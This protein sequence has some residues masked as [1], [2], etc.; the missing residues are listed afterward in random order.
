MNKLYLIDGNALAY[1]AFYAIP[2]LATSKGQPTN[3]IY[4]FI[5]ILRKILKEERVEYLAVFFDS[6]APTFRHSLFPEY[7]AQRKKMPDEL[8]G[9]I[10]IICKAIESLGCFY[11]SLNGYE[12]DDLIASSVKTFR[13][14][15]DEIFILTQDKD[16][17]S[18]IDEKTKV[19][20]WE[21]GL[22]GRTIFDKE[23]V[24]EKFGV[25][26]SS[27]PDLLSLIGDSS[28]NIK[29]AKGIGKKT[30]VS[31]IK[32]YENLD[33]LLKNIEEIENK[34]LKEIIKNEKGMIKISRELVKLKD[35]ISLPFSI[36]N[37][38][39]KELNKEELFSLFSSLEFNR[40]IKELS[41]QN[42]DQ[43]EKT[44]REII[45]P[46]KIPHLEAVSIFLSNNEIIISDGTNAYLPS[47]MD[48]KKILEDERTEKIGYDI[49]SSLSFLKKMGINLKGA[50]F[51]IMIGS[52]LLNPGMKQT[53]NEIILRYLPGETQGAIAIFR[54]KIIL[55]AL[56]KSQGL[57][58]LFSDVEMPLIPILSTMEANGIKVN[59][60][61][62]EEF[63]KDLEERISSLEKKI[64]SLEGEFN[65][66]SPKQLSFILFE[67]LNLPIKKRG[68]TGPSTDEDVLV[69]LSQIH[70]LPR[71]ILE[72]RELS[73]LKSTYV[74]GIISEIKENGRVHCTFNQAITATGRLSSSNPNLQ[75][76][77][78]KTDLS[79]KIR[80]A[81][82]PEEGNVFLK[83]DYSQIELRILAHIS[84]D[85]RLILSFKNQEDIH[86]N[87]AKE[88][89]GVSNITEEMRRKAKTINFGIIYGMTSY[90]LSKELGI[91]P[92][93]SQRMIDRYFSLHPGVLRYITETI[94]KA[95][96]L[97]YVETLWGRRRYI[98]DIFSKV[99]Q[100][101]EFGERAS[102][103]MP[104]QGTC[105]DL[106]KKAMIDLNKKMP[107]SAKLLLTVHDEL[108]FEMPKEEA[109]YVA[110]I[111]IESMENIA[112]FDVP[113]KVNISISKNWGEI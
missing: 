86:S 111:V 76:I 16:I 15:F 102:I 51:D 31:L 27:I 44:Q 109:P 80:K 94:E 105:A 71:L 28:D 68:K 36:L 38:K 69:F 5:V 32:R 34:R 58:S 73:K 108:L 88:L 43:K 61:Y 104:I 101:R 30:G 49:K 65:I 52:H 24:I 55:E 29:G 48:L 13:D 35:D 113:L 89:Y 100:I 8:A 81:F 17:L 56:L 53:L 97:G 1:R 21:K 41:L 6:K 26:P 50:L 103:N 90:G 87:T 20:F 54:L 3:A 67:K 66:N 78:T 11:F 98:Q 106:I 40:L 75:N 83:A 25:F 33:N 47:F 64:Y 22:E 46:S 112:S 39:I 91:S 110:P 85:P 70:P 96:R 42:K 95:K 60:A 18:L 2:S 79:K 93:D 19:I 4:G 74:D 23:K 7:K 63:G 62:L 92:Q 59:K 77:P 99:K 14:N 12:A 107:P 84:Q 57:F 9:Q 10:P 82:I 72:Y 37:L 45:S